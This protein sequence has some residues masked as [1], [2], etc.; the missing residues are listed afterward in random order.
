MHGDPYATYIKIIDQMVTI[1]SWNTQPWWLA[2]SCTPSGNSKEIQEGYYCIS[3]SNHSWKAQRSDGTGLSM[4]WYQLAF[5]FGVQL[6]SCVRLFVTPWTAACQAS[7]SFTISWS[8]LNL[9]SI[10]S[11]MP[12]H[13]LLPPSPFAFYLSQHQGLFRWIGSFHEVVKVLVL[14]ALA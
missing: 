13:P 10:E 3:S 11:V 5:L 9:M 14:P 6:L 2:S 8:L 4:F 7:L 12:S 1:G